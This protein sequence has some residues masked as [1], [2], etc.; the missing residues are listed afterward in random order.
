M[1]M[2][3][4]A[5]KVE[6][7]QGMATFVYYC[8]FT[9]RKGRKTPLNADQRQAALHGS[10]VM[11]SNGTLPLIQTRTLAASIVTYFV[12]LSLLPVCIKT[13]AYIAA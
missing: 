1:K 11:Y 9:S 10:V 4:P 2:K 13:K 5:K 3:L 6:A 8:I 12:A 7:E